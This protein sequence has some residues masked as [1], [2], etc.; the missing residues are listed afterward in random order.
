MHQ[1]QDQKTY[2]LVKEMTCVLASTFAF[3]YKT[4][5][6]HW[7]VEGPHFPE[8]HTLFERIYEEVYEQVDVIAEKIRMLRGYVNT[9]LVQLLQM[10]EVKMG[11]RPKDAAEM[12]KCL[13]ADSV[14]MHGVLMRAFN[15]AQACNDQAVMN[16]L[17]ERMDKHSKHEWMLRAT[18]KCDTN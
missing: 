5:A 13:E 14:V 17:A 11:M 15:A 18:G 7:D 16:Y 3:Y 8:L 2:D 6:F 10:S 12:V 9:D 1:G 4:H